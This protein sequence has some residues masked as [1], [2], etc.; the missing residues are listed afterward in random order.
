[1]IRIKAAVEAANYPQLEEKR[2]TPYM[3]HQPN[4]ML[5]LAWAAGFLA[6]LPVAASAGSSGADV[7][8]GEEIYAECS[9]CHAV[10]E[11]LVGPKHCGVFGRHAG[12]VP[13]FSYSDVMKR[14]RF[15]WDEKH[16]DDFL[17]S[18]ISYL[19][20]TNMGY[21]G[22]D[23]TQDRADLIAYLREAMNPAVC[24]NQRQTGENENDSQSPTETGPLQ[25]M[26]PQ[27]K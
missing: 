17:K 16:L 26:A 7:T 3:T 20:G 11:T 22:L 5:T 8:H 18:P 24:A 13:D 4:R 21:A 23:S 6:F 14:A 9:G 25:K 1:M 2:E 10:N 19:N 15:V 27:T 12:T